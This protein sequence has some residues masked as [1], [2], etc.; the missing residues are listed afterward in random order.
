MFWNILTA[1]VFLL[2]CGIHLFFAYKELETHRRYTKLFL[3]P[4]LMAFVISLQQGRWTI[5]LIAL[6]FGFFGDILLI[7]KHNKVMFLLGE[8]C[9][10][11][12]H[13]VYVIL[14]FLE[15]NFANP[16]LAILLTIGIA[17]I[18][19]FILH[20]IFKPYYKS[21]TI[22]NNIYSTILLVSL[23]YTVLVPI[24]QG[25]YPAILL[26]IGAICFIISDSLIAYNLFYKTVKRHDFYIMIFYLIAQ[27]LL[28]L[29][30]LL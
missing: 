25:I 15:I 16:L 19:Q 23:G 27:T 4:L 22:P 6:A 20:R 2:T 26:P 30:L 28:V 5:L 10:F 24:Y 3:M 9:F 29:G 1:S 17:M 7:Y 21:L 14:F 12:G 11:L 8:L 13:I 18:L